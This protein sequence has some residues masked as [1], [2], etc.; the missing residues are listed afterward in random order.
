MNSTRPDSNR[1]IQNIFN[2]L[3]K[4][5]VP[6]SGGGIL[7][8]LRADGTWAAPPGTGSGI[9]ELTGDVT[10]GPGTGSQVATIADDVVTNAKVSNMAANTVK[11]NATASI[12]DPADLSIGI[13]TVIGRV[14]GNIVAAALVDAQ[15]DATGITTRTKLP[16][17][18]AY[19]D[20]ANDFGANIQTAQQFNIPASS[21][22]PLSPANS[23]YTFVEIAAGRPIFRAK[24]ETG[25]VY[26]II[27]DQVS[28][29]R[30]VTGSGMTKGQ[31]VYIT[32][33]NLNRPLV[34]LVNA[35]SL[36]TAKVFGILLEDIAD[37]SNGLCLNSGQIKNVNTVGLTEGSRL[38]TQTTDGDFGPTKPSIPPNYP[39]VIGVVQNVHASNGVISFFPT[40][41]R[42]DF[43]GTNVVDWNIGSSVDA[44]GKSV[45]FHNDIGTTQVLANPTGGRILTLPDLTGNIPLHAGDI[46]GGTPTSPA[47]L[48]NAVTD[49]KLRDSAGFS[50]IG[51]STTG[52][53]DPA[54]IIAADETV[55]GRTAVG[56]LVFAQVA[57]GQVANNAVDNTKIRDSSALS[58]I[59]RSANSSGD[60]ADISAAAASDAVLRESGSVLG[61]GTIATAGVANNA[62]DNTKLRD[63]AGFSVIG[64]STTGSGDPA[65]IT[66]IA[67]QVLRRSGSGDLLFGTLVTN[68]LGNNQ[69]TNAKLAQMAANTIK[70]NNT[71]GAADPLD[72]T[73]AQVTAML[74]LFTSTLKGLVPLSGGG[75]TNFLRADGTWA[76]P[77]SGSGGTWTKFVQN[78]GVARRSG[79]FDVTG[80]S[81]LTTDNIIE[82]LQTN[83]PISSK[84][85]AIDEPEMDQI[86][87]TARALNSTSF[88]CHWFSTNGGVVVG[89]YAFAWR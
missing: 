14:A 64:K 43:E 35:N 62:I 24:G 31:L 4:G 84:G 37:S 1:Q 27:G 48:N 36:V 23:I 22:P 19:E 70:G 75:T 59:G 74:D 9:T 85:N 20:E 47:I 63:S 33:G 29:V 68:H 46:A 11:A 72:L 65:D 13:N 69:V 26:D 3:E 34:G 53:G 66:A 30:N 82:V 6:E 76:A 45:I 2:S 56:N 67:D 55:L 21:E 25:V 88:R 54:D 61:F 87:L 7:N 83:D 10:A 78:L 39:T 51:K 40:V 77:P 79:T 18:I 15:V 8:F 28:V 17:A 38:Y 32:G 44:G 16:S 5:L 58:V 12:A 73:T 52:T 60:P 86:L 89:N 57:T 49:A 71:G 80:L 42:G 81:G 41:L 50:V